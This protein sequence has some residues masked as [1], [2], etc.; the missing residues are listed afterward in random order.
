MLHNAKEFLKVYQAAANAGHEAGI[1]SGVKKGWMQDDTSA[2]EW[3]EQHC[4]S[5]TANAT[6]SVMT[7]TSWRH[8]LYVLDAPVAIE[9]CVADHILRLALGYWKPQACVMR[10]RS[11]KTIRA[12][13]GNGSRTRK[14]K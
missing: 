11:V 4:S 1:A 3:Q 6:T 12:R 5:T 10:Y 8:R 9:I 7:P 2:R 14:L 13:V